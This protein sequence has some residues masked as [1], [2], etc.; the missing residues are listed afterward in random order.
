M[1]ASVSTNRDRVRVLLPIVVSLAFLIVGVTT[2]DHRDPRET[3]PPAPLPAP[4]TL[5]GQTW[6][7]VNYT[8][9]DNEPRCDLNR[10]GIVAGYHDVNVRNKVRSQLTEMR[11][12]GIETLRLIV[13][14]QPVTT[15]QTWGV[16]AAPD[17]QLLEPYR[18]NLARYFAD[19][20]DAG[21]ARLT[22][23]FGP[24]GEA[25]PVHTDYKPARLE[26]NWR[27]LVAVRG[28]VAEA[29][30]NSFAVDLLNE[31]PPG[32]RSPE[33]QDRVGDYLGELYGRY[34]RRWG[35]Q[36]VIVSVIASEGVQEVKA[37]LQLVLEASRTSAGASPPWFDLHVGYDPVL[38]LANLRNADSFLDEQGLSQPFVVGETA[39]DSREVADALAEFTKTSKRPLLE[40]LAWPL[41]RD[42]PCLD[43]SVAPPYQMD[44][45]R[46]VL[47]PTD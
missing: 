37:R 45:Y 47:Q 22:V 43:I 17:G 21:F 44:V 8:H 35:T 32:P 16:V 6:I 19:V 27:F 25:N 4:A 42:R 40:V 39:Y 33:L 3:S 38:A 13:W 2:L 20:R 7:G 1:S 12:V 11:R 41:T 30:L 29:G 18:S 15:G 14:H 46:E 26:D 5:S 28:L 9:H 24:T 36:D 10:H 31:G 34:A 23:A